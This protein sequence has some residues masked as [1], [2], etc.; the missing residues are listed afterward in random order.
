[1]SQSRL[2]AIASKSTIREY[3]QGAARDATSPVA[4]FLAPTVEVSSPTGYY[5]VYDDKTRFLVPDTRRAIGGRATLLG[6]EKTDATFNCAPHALDVPVDQ[7]EGMADEGIENS[8]KEASDLAAE[9]GGL[10]HEKSTI[11][12]AIAAVTSGAEDIDF[13]AAA[14]VV[15]QIDAFLIEVIKAARYGSLM[16]LGLLFGPT[17]FRRLKNHPSIKARFPV[18]KGQIVNPTESDIMSL[19]ITKPEYRLSL[20]VADSAPMGKTAS[21]NFLL[22]DKLLVFA[23][24]ANPTRRDPSFMKTFRLRGAWMAPRVYQRDDGRVE[25]AAMDWSEQV[26]VTNSSAA[27]LLAIKAGS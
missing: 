15:D 22:D 14:D 20:M 23:R 17:Y 10:A 9:V 13:A 12:T 2:A 27:Q 16:G 5:R 4:D 19:F 8:L 21:V 7:M 3:A 18:G 24:K 26:V 25:V 11:D 6:W 1:M